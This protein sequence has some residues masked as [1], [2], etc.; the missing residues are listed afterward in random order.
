[1]GTEIRALR[2]IVTVHEGQWVFRLNT[3]IAP[4]GGAKLA[5]TSDPTQTT[6]EGAKATANDNA[7]PASGPGSKTAKTPSKPGNASGNPNAK[8]L[9]YPFTLLEIRENR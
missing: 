5:V 1:M 2:I 4:K 7:A 6:Q 9:N 8:K 3:V